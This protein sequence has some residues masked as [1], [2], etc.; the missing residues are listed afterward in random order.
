MTV[1]IRIPS[2]LRELTQQQGVVEVSANTVGG[3]LQELVASYDSLEGKLLSSTGELHSFVNVFVG[4]HNIR[5]L[6]GLATELAAGQTV[7]IVPALAGG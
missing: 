1:R 3:A 2:N 6:Q 5:D 4:E 7:L